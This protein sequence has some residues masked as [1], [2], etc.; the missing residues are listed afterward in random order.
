MTARAWSARAARRGCLCLL[1]TGLVSGALAQT[2]MTKYLPQTLPSFNSSQQLSD[3]IDAQR[4]NAWSLYSSA[5]EAH[6]GRGRT[7]QQD[8]DM[9]LMRKE[10]TAQ[11]D[12][13]LAAARKSEA[14][15]APVEMQ[16][17]LDRAATLIEAER[18]RATVLWLYWW[19]Q[20]LIDAHAQNLAALE[21]RLPSDDAAA[22]RARITPAVEAF[23]ATLGTA[24]NAATQDI[25]QQDAAGEAL[26]AAA[27]PVF[28]A[29][30]K[31][32]GQLAGLV[33]AEERSQDKTPLSRVREG[34]C[35]EPVPPSGRDKAVP[36]HGFP[37]AASF[38]P[39]SSRRE[40]FEGAV[41]IAADISATGC[42]EKAE[43]HSSSGVSELDEG[44]LELALQ[45]KYVPAGHDNQG[46]ASRSLF[47]IQ[48]RLKE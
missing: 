44:A 22:R 33:S 29:Y 48:F 25:S 42:I 32:R 45:G 39:A 17:S 34:P 27:Q 47:R 37:D 36:A 19:F 35:P 23:A 43:V 1:F 6:D 18:Y 41:V 46:V 38:Y 14:G 9:W 13:L 24:M 26:M 10:V 31:E 7:M 2:S 4:H 8:V 16:K 15:N 3:A 5:G 21:A 11:L 40:Y 30:N 20:P 28:A 12:T